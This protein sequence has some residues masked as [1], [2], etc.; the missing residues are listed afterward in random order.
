MADNDIALMAHLMRRAGFGAT[1]EELE[2]YVAKG[3]EATVDELVNTE[4]QPDVDLDLM[5]RYLPEYGE[6]AGIDSNQ[7]SW[8]YRMIN[9]KRPPSG[10]DGPLLARDTLHRL[11]QGGQ[12]PDDDRLHKSVPRARHG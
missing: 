7:Q 6:L 3:Y 4:S 10:E 12:W 11:R 8:V 2:A 9:T 1:R 5:E